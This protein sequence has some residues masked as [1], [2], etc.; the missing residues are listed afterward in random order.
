MAT[1]IFYIV[2]MFAF[3]IVAG[4]LEKIYLLIVWLLGGDIRW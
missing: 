2:S 4:I 1:F 3:F